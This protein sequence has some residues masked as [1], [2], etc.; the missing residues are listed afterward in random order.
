MITEAY[1]DLQAQKHAR[2]AYGTSGRI[3]AEAVSQLATALNT[4]D[5]LD[6]GCGKRTLET[7]LGYFIRNYDPAFPELAEPPKYPAD[8]V[9]CSD[10][11]EHIE[12]EFL[13]AVL[14]DLQRLT[15]KM[16]YFVI[17][18]G[19]AQKTLADGRNAHLI[20]EGPRWWLPKIMQRFNLKQFVAQKNCFMVLVKPC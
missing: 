15:R 9:V 1:R 6:Y 19:P 12:P 11:L 4:T 17:A 13:D 8:L 7:A 5:I 3:H 2:G 18:T 10:V 16:G 14:D 20:Q